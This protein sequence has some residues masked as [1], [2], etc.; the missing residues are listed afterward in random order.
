MAGRCALS[1]AEICRGLH[2][3]TAESDEVGPC[4]G[5]HCPGRSPRP[6]WPLYITTQG[7]TTQ[8]SRTS[9]QHRANTG[10]H[11]HQSRT[12]IDPNTALHTVQSSFENPKVPSVDSRG[13]C[14][15]RD[16]SPRQINE[17][18]ECKGIECRLPLRIRLKHRP[19]PQ[20]VGEGCSPSST[21]ANAQGQPT[22]VHVTDRAAQFIGDIPDF[23]YTAPDLGGAALGVQL[24]CDIKPGLYDLEVFSFY[25]SP[26][27]IMLS[28]CHS[29]FSYIVLC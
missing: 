20:C 19:K 22:L 2:C 5:A 21:A 25:L 3:Y 9:N 4:I 10:Y 17:T 6:S 1:I 26:K 23:G 7:R 16:C 13:G 18:R 15:G 28:N 29:F 27:F 14:T 12:T 11:H 8:G 24:T